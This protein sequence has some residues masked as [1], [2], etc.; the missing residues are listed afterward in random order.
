MYPYLRGPAQFSQFFYHTDPAAG[1]TYGAAFQIPPSMPGTYV[2]PEPDEP[3]PTSPASSA[4]SSTDKSFDVSQSRT[5]A[6]ERRG[7]PKP[8]T[9]E[10]HQSVV[11]DNFMD[12]HG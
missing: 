2:A 6:P 8:P 5:A 7:L 9:I 11:G 10:S 3:M 1:A 4:L 12:V